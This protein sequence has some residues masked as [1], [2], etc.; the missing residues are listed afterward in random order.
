MQHV[1]KLLLASNGDQCLLFIGDSFTDKIRGIVD[2]L[3]MAHAQDRAG[4][5]EVDVARHSALRLHPQT[6]NSEAERAN[7]IT[8]MSAR[9]KRNRKKK[10][11]YSP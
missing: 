9:P 5:D 3:E 4:P 6:S 2:E 8:T 10:V 7:Q 11:I 1:P